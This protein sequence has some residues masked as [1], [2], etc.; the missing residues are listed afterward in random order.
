MNKLLS[1]RVNLYSMT[2]KAKPKIISKE[3]KKADSDEHHDEKAWGGGRGWGWG[4]TFQ[5]CV[6]CVDRMSPVLARSASFDINREP[7]EASSSFL[8]GK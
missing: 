1:R 4:G 5:G 6:T 3:Q 2:Q 8:R 7:L